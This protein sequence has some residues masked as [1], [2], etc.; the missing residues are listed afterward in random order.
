[1]S[2]PQLAL[3]A[4]WHCHSVLHYSAPGFHNACRSEA[5]VE[6]QHCGSVFKITAAMEA[7]SGPAVQT[8]QAA[9]N[10]LRSAPRSKYE[11]GPVRIQVGI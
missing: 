5:V 9:V 7:L 2:A 3:S 6:C 8:F 4:C 11:S 10:E 1:M